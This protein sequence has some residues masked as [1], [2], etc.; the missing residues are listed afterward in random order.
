MYGQFCVVHPATDT[1]LVTNCITQDMGGVLNAYYDEVL[2]KYESDA[3]AD[4]PR[5]RS[6]CAKRRRICATNA[7]CRRTTAARF[8]RNT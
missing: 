7:I 1:I 8:R 5:L 3:V 6:N 2:M 4:E